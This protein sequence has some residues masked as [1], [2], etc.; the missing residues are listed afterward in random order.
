ME[1]NTATLSE[2]IFTMCVPKHCDTFTENLCCRILFIV[3]D[4]EDFWKPCP[5][6]CVGV[7]CVAAEGVGDSLCTLY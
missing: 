7:D 2:E 4:A 1:N 6:L 5:G 3:T